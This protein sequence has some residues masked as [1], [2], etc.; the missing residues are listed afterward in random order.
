MAKKSEQECLEIVKKAYCCASGG[1]RIVFDNSDRATFSKILFS[2]KETGN[3]ETFPDFV[4]EGAIIEH[5]KVTSAKE[6]RKG[7]AFN[8]KEAGEI[9]KHEALVNGSSLIPG[10]MRVMS[11]KY[12]YTLLSYRSFC[13]SVKRNVL[14][15]LDSLKKFNLDGNLAVFMLEQAD[16]ALA[17]YEN[18]VFSRFYRHSG[19]G[20]MLSWLKENA[21]DVNYIIYVASDMIE[22]IDMSKLTEMIERSKPDLDIRG[23]RHVGIKSTFVLDI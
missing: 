18:D 16:A 22:I 21:S 19:D 17:I 8:A 11:S 15:H 5:F 23:G 7:S 3:D 13:D 12:E 2:A 1:T 14:N 6:N 10:S 4:C 9:R 20:L